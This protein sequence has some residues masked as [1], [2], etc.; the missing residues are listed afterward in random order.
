MLWAM[1]GDENFWCLENIFFL[2]YKFTV[3]VVNIKLLDIFKC[4]VLNVC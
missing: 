2:L 1:L 4:K 3:A